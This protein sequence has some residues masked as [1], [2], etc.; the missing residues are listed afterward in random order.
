MWFV[1][2]LKKM[3]PQLLGNSCKAAATTPGPKTSRHGQPWPRGLLHQALGAKDTDVKALCLLAVQV[4]LLL[5]SFVKEEWGL[6]EGDL[7][8]KDKKTRL[9]CRIDTL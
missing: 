5:N 1:L 7:S 8:F 4:W 2:Q 6:K 3:Q 9:L